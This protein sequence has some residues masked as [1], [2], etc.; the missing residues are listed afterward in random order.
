MNKEYIYIQ[1]KVIVKDENGTQTSLEYYDNLDKVLIQ[2][3]LI[4]SMEDKISYLEKESQDYKK[5]D[6][7]HYIP[8]A[9]PFSIF[10]TTIGVPAFNSWLSNTDNLCT[11]VNTIF[12]TMNE[13]VLYSF[14]FFPLAT[15]IDF[16]MYRDYKKSIK[17]EKGINNELEFLKKQLVIEK[18]NLDGLKKDKTRNRENEEF[19][20]VKV[21]DLEILKILESWLN[22]YYDLGYDGEKYYKYYL[23]GKLD[24]KLGEY[25]NKTGINAAKRYLEEKG[26]TLVKSKNFNE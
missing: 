17:K 14:L 8:I 20:V 19:R 6:N 15:L 23:Q 1:G 7:K 5:Y 22:L 16:E 3:N 26:P 10:M 21:D 24:D 13:S 11:S 18:E 4:E 25:Y 2:E 12:G 9:L